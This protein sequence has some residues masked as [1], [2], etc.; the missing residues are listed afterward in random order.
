MLEGGAE[1]FK[2]PELLLGSLSILF[3]SLLTE[4]GLSPWSQP[5]R[6]QEI[7]HYYISSNTKPNKI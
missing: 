3:S 4:Q 5:D 2:E 6:R 1:R 7:T